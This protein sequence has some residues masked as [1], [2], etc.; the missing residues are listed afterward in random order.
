MD[1]AGPAGALETRIDA[2]ETGTQWAVLCHP[3]PQYGGNMHDA[4][5][6]VLAN[7]LIRRDIG[8][9]RFNFRGVG[10]S[11]GSYDQGDGEQQDLKA[12]LAWITSEYELPNVLLGGYS[13][14]SSIAWQV[15]QSVDVVSRLMLV[16][17]PVGAM[18]FD[19]PTPHVPIDAFAGDGDEFVR[20][21]A[22]RALD[23]VRVHEIAGANHFFMGRWDDLGEAIRSAL[24]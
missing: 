12:V 8:V 18:T 17:P 14:G 4:V 5:L 9:L 22:L 16:A 10:R 11:E 19:G 23:G 13:F 24:S 1:I 15:A 2:P 20:M 6:D 21:D 3:H 7:E